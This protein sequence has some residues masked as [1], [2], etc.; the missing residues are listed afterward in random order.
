M[1]EI[2]KSPLLARELSWVQK[3][4]PDN[5][6]LNLN[7]NQPVALIKGRDNEKEGW[8]AKNSIKSKWSEGTDPFVC[9]FGLS[10]IYYYYYYYTKAENALNV[11][12]KFLNT[13]ILKY[14]QILN[15]I[16]RKSYF[17]RYPSQ[18]LSVV[19]TIRDRLE[20]K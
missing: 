8:K 17:I 7:Q 4:W 13:I 20:W 1:A 12:E 10:Y 14:E 6:Y 3:F 16:S 9:K 19:F 18:V 2:V 11:W 5:D 15:I